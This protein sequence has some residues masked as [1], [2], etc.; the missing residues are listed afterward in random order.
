MSIKVQYR[1]QQR[2]ELLDCLRA[3]PGRHV[4][5]A[6][7]CD[8]L[9]AQGRPVGTTTI[10][11]HLERMVDE[12]LVAKYILDANTP[13]CFEYIGEG[14]P[15]GDTVCFHCKC[16]KC[17]RLIHLHCDELEGIAAHLLAEHHFTLNAHRTVFYGVCSDCAAN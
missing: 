3:T 12:G 2:E 11:R 15:C 10:Y 16:E 13:A 4:T 17:G 8:Q 1:T 6:E 5:V 9:K 7:I 14:N